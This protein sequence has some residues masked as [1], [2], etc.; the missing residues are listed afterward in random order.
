MKKIALILTLTIVSCNWKVQ[1]RSISI[2]STQVNDSTKCDSTKI[3][4][5]KSYSLDSS[6]NPNHNHILP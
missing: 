5:S 2:D 1:N 4:T 3:D 6:M